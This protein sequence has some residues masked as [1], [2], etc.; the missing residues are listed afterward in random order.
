[1]TTSAAPPH[2][3]ATRPVDRRIVGGVAAGLSDHLNVPVLWIRIGFVVATWFNAAGIIGYLLLWRFLPLSSPDDTPGIASATRAGM[4][5]A[6][7]TS[8]REIAQTVAIGAVGLGVFALIS[9]L[10]GGVSSRLLIPV[11]AGALGVALIWRQLDDAT[12]SSWLRQTRGAGYWARIA[13]GLGL[14]GL[15]AVYVISEG[16]G[17][18]ATLDLVAAVVVAVLGIGLILG[19]WIGSLWHDLE[20]ERRERIRSQERADMA[21]H[22][23]DSVLQTLALLQKNAADPRT[24]ATLARRQERELRTWLYGD[25]MPG[26]GTAVRSLRTEAEDVETTHRVAVELVAVGDHPLSADAVAL[27]RA[28]REAM[29]NAAKH[30]GSERVDVYAEFAADRGEVFVRDR[31]VGFDPDGVAD[32][33]QGIR[34][35]I[36]ER[37]RRHGG[38]ATVKSTPGEG[39]EI[40]LTMPWDDPAEEDEDG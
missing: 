18:N 29:V 9:I 22:L 39:T 7:R 19:P 2:P 4:R 10:G 25:E 34:G 27:V 17:W 8:A 26:D 38:E 1:M 24:V 16:R 6:E 40:V 14:V 32:D 11:L 33:R 28:A 15:A 20:S 13:A 37:M 21:A 36:V 5:G 35:S 30:A 3:R 31:G 23:H 12:W